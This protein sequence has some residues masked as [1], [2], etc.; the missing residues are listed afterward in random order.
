M[1]WTPPTALPCLAILATLLAPKAGA[2]TPQSSEDSVRV[3]LLNGQ[4]VEGRIVRWEPSEYFVVES[5]VGELQYVPFT[6]LTKGE[7]RALRRRVADSNPDGESGALR[8]SGRF[9]LGSSQRVRLERAEAKRRAWLARGGTLIGYELRAGVLHF[10]ASQVS[11]W[12]GSAAARIAV[13]GLSLPDPERGGVWSAWSLGTGAD[14]AALT[15]EAPGTSYFDPSSNEQISSG[16]GRTELGLL[17][18]PLTLS[19][20]VGLGSFR[21]DTRWKGAVIGM[22]YSPSVTVPF[23]DGVDGEATVNYL[24]LELSLDYAS[25]EAT[26][27]QMAKEAHLRVFGFVLPPI[28]DL[29]LVVAIGGGAAWY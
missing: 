4:V 28:A 26:A 12:G 22:R 14:F 11:G 25:F 21:S 8:R 3:R 2:A 18:V 24:G 19:Y 27:E 13:M 29:P 10:A 17:Q 23:G 16:G 7:A 5:T 20:F 15:V 1:R 6:L 9:G